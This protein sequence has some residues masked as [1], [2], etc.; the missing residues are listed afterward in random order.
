MADDLAVSVAGRDV[1]DGGAVETVAE[2]GRPMVLD[3]SIRNLTDEQIV[4]LRV[5]SN[6]PE[7]AWSVSGPADIAPRAGA[8]L[9]MA[10]DAGALYDAPATLKRIAVDL[11]YRKVRRFG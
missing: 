1:S 2:Y 7:G 3:I 9:A 5:L 10:I 11:E 4:G 8:R 6:I